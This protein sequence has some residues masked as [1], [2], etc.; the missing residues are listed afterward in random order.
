MWLY[1]KKNQFEIIP[2]SKARQNKKKVLVLIEC[3]KIK[4][5]TMEHFKSEIYRNY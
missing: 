2:V 3:E 5:K 4:P 1:T